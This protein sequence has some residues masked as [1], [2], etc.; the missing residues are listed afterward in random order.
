MSLGEFNLIEK[1]F[2]ANDSGEGIAL[3]IGDDCALINIPLNTSL[4]VTT[5]TLNEGIHF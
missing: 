2:T 3:G 4:A 5:D 1:Y